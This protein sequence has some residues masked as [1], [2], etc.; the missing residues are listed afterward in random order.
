MG[1]ATPRLFTPQVIYLIIITTISVFSNHNNHSKFIIIITQFQCFSITTLIPEFTWRIGQM[2]RKKGRQ[3]GKIVLDVK[4]GVVS[5][6]ACR[7]IVVSPH[8]IIINNF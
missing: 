2:K 1:V 3:G 7:Y 6:P 5:P 4:A 8:K